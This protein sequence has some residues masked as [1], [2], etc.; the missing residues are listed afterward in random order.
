MK[1]NRFKSLLLMLLIFSTSYSQQDKCDCSI[2]FEELTQKIEENYI[3]LAQL[4]LDGNDEAYDKRTEDFKRKAAN[5]AS[6]GCTEILSEFLYY[7][8]DGHLFVT[9]SPNYTAEELTNFKADRKNNKSSLKGILSTLE[10]EK[11]MAEKNGL[12]GIIGKWSDG[13]SELAIIKDEGYYR[14]YILKS[15]NENTH[16]GELKAEFEPI[17]YSN[18]FQGVYYSYDNYASKY[19]R[20]DIYKEA[21]LLS[22]FGTS[23]WGKIGDESREIEMI[24]H[25]DIKQPRIEK[26]DDYTTLFS[27]PSFSYDYNKFISILLENQTILK[28]TTNLIFDI[29][30]NTGGN[31]IYLAFMDAYADRVLPS[32]Q[33]KILAS[34]ATLKYFE[35][36]SKNNP[37]VY[38]N[39]V[40]RIKANMGKI[41]DG[42][43]YPEKK[44]KPYETKIKNVAILTDRAVAS[45]A[46]SFILHSKLASSK[47]KVFGSPTQ[48]MIDYT[49]VNALKLKTS[50][51]QNILFGYPT[52]TYHKEVIPKNGYNK[53]GII[54]DVIIRESVKDKVKFVMRYFSRQE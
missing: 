33:G 28:N 2:V 45:A 8:D 24:N 39:V 35:G 32:N 54:P 47:V 49:S 21:S 17:P 48:G 19:V 1:K 50:G 41:I 43:K 29:R 16:T 34:G 36:L 13:V 18:G 22:I 11:N 20:G 10:Y 44:F 52:S 6:R 4:R 31:A 9:E 40:E 5:T 42:P 25:K 7:F 53:T 37:E 46:E 15:V 23:V 38:D 26:L 14:A 51:D 30:G 3:V 12:D 27:I